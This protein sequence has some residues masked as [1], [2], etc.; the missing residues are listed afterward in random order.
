MNRKRYSRKS[1]RRRTRRK[2]RRTR[3]RERRYPHRM[4][5]KRKSGTGRISRL[6]QKFREWLRTPLGQHVAKSAITIATAFAIFLMFNK[7]VKE[8]LK[9]DYLEEKNKLKADLQEEKKNLKAELKAELEEQKE[10]A[11]KDVELL[12]NVQQ[13]NLKMT[14]DDAISRFASYSY[15][16]G[17]VDKPKES[18][19]RTRYQDPPSENTRS[20]AKANE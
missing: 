17:T 2:R 3:G 4:S 8:P 12:L 1:Y 11:A 5:T 18:K 13:E 20:K 14:A 10:A 19:F 6:R 7:T 15:V 16:K 9:K